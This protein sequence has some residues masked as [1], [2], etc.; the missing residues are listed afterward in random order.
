MYKI[1]EERFQE[2]YK[3][4]AGSSEQTDEYSSYLKSVTENGTKLFEVPQEFQTNELV[5][6]AF[7]TE[8]NPVHLLTRRAI[9]SS[10]SKKR[11]ELSRFNRKYAEPITEEERESYFTYLSSII[12]L[13]YNKYYSEN[14]LLTEKRL[15]TFIDFFHAV[16]EFY[17]G[18]DTINY[19]YLYR[20]FHIP[21]RIKKNGRRQNFKLS[22]DAAQK[23][24]SLIKVSADEYKSLRATLSSKLET[25]YGNYHI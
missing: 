23:I 21:I 18:M 24:L 16:T 6:L 10:I 7:E 2:L 13:K 19:L 17:S 5:L 14:N 12:N 22:Y 1:A 25:Y 15:Y 4:Y 11:M 3:H 8:K 9:E 20:G